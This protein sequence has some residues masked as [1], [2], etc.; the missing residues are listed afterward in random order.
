MAITETR[1]LTAD[2]L[3]RLDSQGVRGELIRGVLH[4]TK[5]AGLEHGEIAVRLG[6]ELGCFIKPQ[7]LGS[8]AICSGYW[9]EHDPDTVLGADIAYISAAKIPPDVR[10]TGYAEVPPDLVVEIV[11]PSD[12]QREV[13][14][15]AWMWLSYG[16]RLVWVV[17]PDTRTVDV[18]RPG[19]AVVT[20]DEHDKL[21]GVD[22]L[23]GFT[24]VVSE[25]FDT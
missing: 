7:R 25:V 18:Y 1:L 11:S 10:I 14:D 23:P 13:H 4:R 8:L 15:K 21:D 5:P 12:S 16:V 20:F 9:L 17:Q 3:L 2:D 22:M 24:C 19:R 6:F